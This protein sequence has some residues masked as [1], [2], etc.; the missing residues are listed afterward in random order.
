MRGRATFRTTAAALLAIGGVVIGITAQGCS[1]P[2]GATSTT[3]SASSASATSSGA[4]GGAP[5]DRLCMS[6]PPQLPPP[7]TD[8]CPTDEP[9]KDTL[10]AA[11]LAGGLASRCLVQL[12][13]ADVAKSGWPS[14][15]LVDAHRLP[16]FTPL[17]HGPL[18]LPS[19]ARDL[20]SS[21]ASAVAS[22][23]PVAKALATLSSRRGH[24]LVDAC[25]EL[26][27]FAPAAGDATPLAT[28]ILTLDD[29]RG[30]PGDEAALRA[31]AAS[32]PL[33]LQAR[34]AKI[35]GALSLAADAVDDAL[36]PAITGS[37]DR[38]FLSHAASLYYPGGTPLTLDA[39]H[40][41][42]LDAVDLGKISEAAALLAA[43]IE[44][45]D[46][47]SVPDATFPAFEVD[48]PLG[49]IVVHDASP[50]TYAKGGPADGALLLVDLG[51]DDTY[52]VP[53]GASDAK[54]P[55]SVA[56]DV[57]GSD[58]WGYKSIADAHDTGLLP[59]DAA[60]GRY[61]SA[62]TPDQ[63]YGPVTLSKTPRQGSGNAGIG[64]LF[65]LGHEGDTYR[66]LA[67]SQGFGAMGVGVLFDAGGDDDYGAE[68]AAQGSATFGIGLLLDEAGNDHYASFT[69]SQGFGGAE[70]VGAL[71]DADG[72]DV[73]FCDPG[74]PAS[75]G[76]PL[77]FSPQLPGKGNSSMSQGA[78]QGRRPASASDVAYMAGGLGVLRDSRGKDRY[79]GS[80]FAQ[81]AGYWQGLG[82]LLDG[83]T[84]ADKYD[85]LW[86]VQGA[87]AHFSLALFTD[88]G[89][90]DRYDTTFD[91]AATSIGVGHDF[92]AAI[93]VDL[94]GN[95]V[96]HAPGLSLGSGNINGIGLFANVGGDDTYVAAGDPTLGAGNYSA[97]APFGDPRQDAPTIGIFVDSAGS[98]TYTVAGLARM[99]ESSTWSY[100][101]Q[102]YPA[103]QV[104]TTEH[105]CGADAMA[106][107][108]VLP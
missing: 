95:D 82:M 20:E 54:H 6:S 58:H 25:F 90:D 30:Q 32:V 107:M 105:G 68:A 53:A 69:L 94:G 55:V 100:E 26:G 37:T 45:A 19:Y 9:A 104:V 66:S 16:D 41:A 15:M 50:D 60:P 4:G 48:T 62:K 77:Y 52:E 89:G 86:Y 51:G 70:G 64:L 18:R 3:T 47:A 27:P 49:A 7:G 76:H 92:S 88:E 103:P 28:A 39:A 59:S 87:A 99:L 38:A 21:L 108:V 73:Y 43:T 10:D 83:G 91:P 101:P 44:R 65:D 93:H 34:L 23:S 75:G 74:D 98:D 67:A 36:A 11:L 71:L 29:H 85:A 72:D 33:D 84:D 35:V 31:A 102:P 79:T 63:D 56:I 78:A 1:E 81:G 97:E 2:G 96:Y 12:R 14:A 57:R 40:V 5:S 61:A 13:D 22:T 80:V 106:G 46:L 24:A 42:K 17:Y 8:A